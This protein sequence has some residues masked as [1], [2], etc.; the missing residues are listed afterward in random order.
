MFCTVASLN[1][2]ILDFDTKELKN[3]FLM[4]LNFGP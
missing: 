1:H 2:D 3:Y 4:N